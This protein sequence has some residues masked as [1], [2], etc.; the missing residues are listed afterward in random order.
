MKYLKILAMLLLPS[1]FIACSDDDDINNTNAVVGFSSEVI[2]IKENATMVNVPVSVEGEHTGMIKVTVTMKEVNGASVEKDRTVILTSENLLIPAG[3]ESVNA[4]ISTSIYTK[5]E[6]VDRYVVLEITSAEGATIGRS[7]CKLNIQEIVDPY[8]KLVG[9]WTFMGGNK[10]FDVTI[11][12][13][14]DET[15]YNCIGFNGAPCEWRMKYSP[16]GLEVISNEDI[17]TEVDFGEPDWGL[18][19]IR[20]ATFIPPSSLNYNNIPGMWNED[21]DTITFETGICGVIIDSS[22]TFTGSVWFMFSECMMKKK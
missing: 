1:F 21:L 11:T 13:N 15:G 20:L 17:I 5:E 14:E 10:S 9:E 6:N 18:C 4:E 12:A 2:S 3:V 7:N 16:T 8:K 19:S 22:G